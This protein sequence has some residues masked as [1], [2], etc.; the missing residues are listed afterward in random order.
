[1]DIMR[2]TIY[3]STLLCTLVTGILFTFAV[4]VMP[5]IKKLSN[6]DFLQTFKSIDKVI[7]DNSPPFMVVWLGSAL[8]LILSTIMGTWQLEGIDRFLL[9][10]AF[11]IFIFGVQVPT[12]IV[13]IPLN[14]QIQALEI[15]TISDA[16]IKHARSSFEPKWTRWNMV[17]TILAL[18]VSA[19]L[20]Y[21]SLRL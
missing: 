11:L 3:L 15:S 17:R 8:L 6:H 4:V 1:M 9:F 14:N 21:L 5:G 19:L 12:F 20:T 16:E 18:F 10:A 7:Q 13:N 2:I